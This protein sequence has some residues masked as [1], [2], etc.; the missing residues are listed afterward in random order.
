MTERGGGTGVRQFLADGNGWMGETL[1]R[2]DGGCQE[3]G[4][5]GIGFHSAVSASAMVADIVCHERR[6]L[7]GAL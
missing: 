3:G 6:V 5:A 7:F 2:K 4:L 1:L